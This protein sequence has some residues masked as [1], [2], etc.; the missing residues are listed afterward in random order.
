MDL[1]FQHPSKA[2]QLAAH[3]IDQVKVVHPIPEQGCIN[4]DKTCGHS[5]RVVSAAQVTQYRALTCIAIA[6]CSDVRCCLFS[7]K[8]PNDCLAIR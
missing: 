2:A 3:R 7:Y 5:G 4:L 8:R 1:G 6:G